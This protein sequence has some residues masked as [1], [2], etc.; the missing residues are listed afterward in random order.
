[1]QTCDRCE[2]PATVHLTEI[3][4]GAKTESHLCEE[5][6]RALHVPQPSKELQKLLKS[7]TPPGAPEPSS[8]GVDAVCP[9]CGMTYSEFRKSGRFGCARDYEAFGE[10]LERLLKKIHRSTAYTGLSPKG[11]VIEDGEV[12]NAV[13]RARRELRA[14]VE[15]EDYEEA[16]RL[17]DEIRRLE[18]P[19][20]EESNGGTHDQTHDGEG[21]S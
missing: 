6:A 3:K 2:S 16:A 18:S 7:F 11:D 15:L 9:D 20:C 1:M 17:R 14:A 10:P 12:V 5:C 8:A 13:T 4:S 21:A 19:L